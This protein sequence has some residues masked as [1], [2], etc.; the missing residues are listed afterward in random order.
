MYETEGFVMA[1]WKNVGIHIWTRQATLALV[2]QLD[3]LSEAFVPLHPRG[4]SS[5]HV[6]AKNAPLPDEVVRDRFLEVADR[7]AKQLACVGH[8]VEGSGFWASALQSFITGVHWL[9]RRPFKFQICTSISAVAQWL[10]EPHW[11]RTGVSFESR[12]LR[13]ALEY[14]RARAR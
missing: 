7:F 3:V 5:I 4:I 12:E 1:T 11:Q 6:V 2:D 8:V 9:S 10:P 13:R 14:V